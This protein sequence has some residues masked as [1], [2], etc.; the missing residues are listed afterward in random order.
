MPLISTETLRQPAVSSLFLRKST[1]VLVQCRKGAQQ[2][3]FCHSLYHVKCGGGLKKVKEYH[4][5]RRNESRSVSIATLPLILFRFPH[6]ASWWVL[7]TSL[8]RPP[9]VQIMNRAL[10]AGRKIA[11]GCIYQTQMCIAAW[12]LAKQVPCRNI[13]L[14]TFDIRKSVHV[15]P[16]STWWNTIHWPK[17]PPSAAC[18][19]AKNIYVC[20]IRDGGV[21]R[22]GVNL[23]YQAT[24]LGR[25]HGAVKSLIV[26]S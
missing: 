5:G 2:M 17:T 26:W 19:A 11:L 4:Q 13:S 3:E 1:E 21:S 23:G 12:I 20:G 10:T 6:C 9:K 18:S 15:H 25:R 7:R 22:E 8:R 24:R 16:D 14:I